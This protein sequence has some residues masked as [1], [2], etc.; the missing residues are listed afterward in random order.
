MRLLPEFALTKKL[1]LSKMISG[2]LF[3]ST[4]GFNLSQRKNYFIS[5]L[6]NR[7]FLH[8]VYKNLNNH[9]QIAYGEGFQELFYLNLNQFCAKFNLSVTKTF[10]CLQF[11]DRQGIITLTNSI[12]NKASLHFLIDSREV[13]RY[14][15]LNVKD[16]SVIETILRNYTGVF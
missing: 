4:G 8:L 11:L 7:E 12:S 5:N 14:C 1:G 2:Y 6:P 13:I 9:F 16:A 10:A 15:S 3:A